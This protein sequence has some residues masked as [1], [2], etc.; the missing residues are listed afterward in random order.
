[1]RVLV[2]GSQGF[3][4][5]ATINELGATSDWQGFDVLDR[6]DIRYIHDFD[7]AVKAFN[8][9]RILH[10]AAIAR[11]ADADDHPQLAF[12]TNAL[13]TQ[14]VVK[15]AS[16]YKI[17]LVYASTGSVYMPIHIPPP[18]TE[19]FPAVGNSTYACS[20]YLGELYVQRM[21]SPWIILRYA[22][23]YG[24]DKRLHGLVGGFLERIERGLQPTLYGGQQSNDF[25]AIWDV[26]RANRLALE[27]P[28]HCWNNIFN[29]GTGEELTTRE[30]AGMICH[31]F[32]YHDKMEVKPGRTVDPERFVFDVSKA[33][34]MLGFKAEY[35]FRSGLERMKEEIDGSQKT[36]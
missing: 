28:W 21:T 7:I 35:D 17:P 29:I 25:T 16:R 9:S 26:A 14:N 27:A 10:L 36:A 2:T 34:R 31:T 24:K 11:F 22:H 6:L 13:G 4:G 19:G 23:L 1:M 12:E 30:A 32:D 18:I 5:S 20:K 33:E 15:I 3:V 8:P